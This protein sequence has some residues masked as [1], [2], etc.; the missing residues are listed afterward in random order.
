MKG[1]RKTYYDKSC[2]KCGLPG[3]NGRGDVLN[4]QSSPKPA[5]KM[6]CSKCQ[7]FL[8]ERN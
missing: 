8:H 5:R 3:N 6:K 4:K 1:G 2:P 7:S